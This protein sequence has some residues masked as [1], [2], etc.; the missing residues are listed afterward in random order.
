[1]ISREHTERVLGAI[2]KAKK[3]GAKLLLP[4]DY[5]YAAGGGRA[6][7]RD[8]HPLQ[9]NYIAPT[10][11]EVTEQMDLSKMDLWMKEIFGPVLAVI[12]YRHGDLDQAIDLANL[13]KY[14]LAAS[15]WSKS[16]ATSNYVAEGINAKVK[17]VNTNQFVG[18]GGPVWGNL[19]GVGEVLG[20][21][22]L[23]AYLVKPQKVTYSGGPF[24]WI[25]T[26]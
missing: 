24:T 6:R 22:G 3:D 5:D 16:R 7:D 19:R 13:T 1:M 14:D 17:W 9:G 23:D 2:Q 11:F 10:V 21:P 20:K 8:G 15:V 4:S 25:P 18:A 26:A 12:K